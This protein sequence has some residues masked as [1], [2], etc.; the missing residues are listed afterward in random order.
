MATSFLHVKGDIIVDGN[1]KAVVMRGAAL[2]GWMKY[3]ND[4][5]AVSFPCPQTDIPS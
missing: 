1:G 4:R 2:G 3:A 5:I